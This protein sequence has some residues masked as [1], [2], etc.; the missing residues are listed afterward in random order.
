MPL[1]VGTDTPSPWIV[2]GASYASEMKL[3]TDAGIPPRAVLEM[4]TVHAAR[5]LGKA[6]KIGEISLGAAA[7]LLVLA[8]DPSLR[9]ENVR[10]MRMVILRG[11]R[12]DP[13]RL[14]R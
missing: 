12:I 9:I 11:R 2:P 1:T 6:G 10:E 13:A 7:D 4:A 3:L 14:A 5:A 8:G